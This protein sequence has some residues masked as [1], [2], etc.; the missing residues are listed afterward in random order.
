MLSIF[1]LAFLWM[2]AGVAVADEDDPF[3]DGAPSTTASKKAEAEKP[4]EIVW[5]KTVEEGQRRALRDGK[6]VLV[7]AKASWCPVCKKLA[8]EFEKPALQAEFAR[9][10]LV[11]IDVDQAEAE[12]EKLHVVKLPL[13]RILKADGHRVASREGGET[14]EQP[15]EWLKSN[16]EEAMNVPDEI[17]AAAAAPE[18]GDVMKLVRKFD[19]RSPTV[20]E[21]AIRR[22]LHHPQASSEMVVVTFAEGS[23]SARLSAMELLQAW[24]APLD[25]LDPWRPDSFTSERMAKLE[26]WQ[27]EAAK[28]EAETPQELTEAQRAEAGADIAR[29]LK[30]PDAEAG[31]IRERL[32]RFGQSLLPLV[33]ER[34]KEAAGD[35]DRE[36][37]MALRYRLVASEELALQWPGGLLRLAATETAKRQKA[38]EELAGR[39][40]AA[41]QNLLRELFSD[42]DPLVREICLRGLQNIGDEA[43]GALVDLLADPE[44]NVRAAVLKQLEESPISGMVPKIAEYVKTEKDADLVVHAVRFLR[45]VDDKK[46]K[47]SLI[48]L[49]KHES[50]QVRAEA[51][52]AL[53]GSE[54]RTY[55]ITS[56]D[57]EPSEEEKLQADAYTALIELLD[58]K[59]NFV[60]SKAVEGLS[61]A[62]MVVAVDPL[63]KAAESHPDLA[64]SIIN[65]L[66]A[67]QKMKAKA[68]P[69]LR[70]FCKHENPEIRAA[71]LTGIA[72]AVQDDMQ[73]EI[74]AGISDPDSRV[75]IAAAGALLKLFESERNKARNSSRP[76][77]GYAPRFSGSV[78]ITPSGPPPSFFGGVAKILGEIAKQAGSPASAKEVKKTEDSTEQ[79]KAKDQPPDEKPADEKSTDEKPADEKP[80][81]EKPTMQKPFLEA[82]PPPPPV[83]PPESTA[84]PTENQEQK[85]AANEDSAS[86]PPIITPPAIV[87]RTETPH[88]MLLPLNVPPEP[89][90]PKLRIE[91]EVQWDTVQGPIPATPVPVTPGLPPAITIEGDSV[92]TVE[93]APEDDSSPNS[94]ATDEWLQGFY[95]GKTRPDWT[96][97]LV[98]P[99]VKM[100]AAESVEERVAAAM[101]LIPLGKADLAMPVLLE[102]AKEKAEFST[103]AAE[104][105]PWLV[106][107]KRLKLFHDL[108][109]IDNRAG[110]MTLILSGMSQAQDPR[111]EELFWGFL[112]DKE[113]DD[114]LAYRV[115]YSLQQLYGVNRGFS[116]SSGSSA[117]RSDPVK[118]KKL[119]PRTAT[120]TETQRMVALAL[121]AATDNKEALKAADQMV[122]DAT[123]GEDLRRD[124]FQIKLLLQPDA[125]SRNE[126]AV[127]ALKQSDPARSKIALKVL[128]NGVS[129]LEF[130]RD[131]IFLSVSVYGNDSEPY[132]SGQPI[133]PHPP[134]G[135][136]VDDVKPL[137]EDSN[138][139]IAAYA[140]YLTALFAD[141]AGM[142]PLLAYWKQ[143]GKQNSTISTLIYRAA[144]VLDDPK[145]IPE[146][147]EVY[148]KL[149]EY[150]LGRFYWTIRIMTGPE[151]LKFRKEIR[152]KHGMSKLQ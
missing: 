100:L 69:H 77:I 19:D 123:L 40:T 12:A 115:Y 4:A 53:G 150:E 139:E 20:R 106:R 107:E 3:E 46:A 45:A 140:G 67:G 92:E 71:A 119:I 117:G 44:P 138:P 63:V 137:V 104:A 9:W 16:Y 102:A 48:G 42:P 105:L 65:I 32:A 113:A 1:F 33:Y 58:D 145:Y 73:E 5:L 128:V 129:G 15:E 29:M 17:L 2:F 22:L 13:L 118:A 116:T 125:K 131:R 135:L 36:R 151:I 95:E 62:D 112:A 84:P 61:S 149:Q 6:P 79:E 59:D 56:G 146:L 93:S 26:A 132:T 37:L 82:P 94:T 142:E 108:R 47:R 41:D 50:W 43:Q 88:E 66:A 90:A 8:E 31:S 122:D 136:K 23:L 10:T 52:S 134:K 35:R 114:D 98:E 18:S 11:A 89:T 64:L 60:I 97:K 57:S 68:L 7:L 74:T 75:R 96:S 91:G 27:K 55:G 38:A 72:T 51:A 14:L 81:D 99:L 85:P 111:D 70:A 25:G 24:K 54:H 120:G 78:T 103:S 121:L 28:S 110:Q 126:L 21:A 127:E 39:A 30:V 130:L 143:Q 148:D 87:E 34:L 76:T 80:A 101:A 83:T 141:P 124:A 86:G 133:V 49:L 147:R 109:A 144:A 152:D